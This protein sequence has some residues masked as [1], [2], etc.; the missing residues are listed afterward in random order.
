[1]GEKSEA[2]LSLFL[3]DRFN[4]AQSVLAVFCEAY[5]LD[6][7]TALRI[8]SGLGGGIRCGELCGAVSGAA[9]VIGLKYGQFV[10]GDLTTKNNCYQK[11]LA[12]AKEFRNLNGSIVCRELLGHDVWTNADDEEIKKLSQE[13]HRTVCPKL[14]ES[15]VKI[16]EETG[17]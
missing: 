2:A 13:L 3:N 10:A 14:I 6:K 17:Y 7:E 1:M 11:A 9:Q 4:C 5:G 12:F 16:L 15:A 8:A